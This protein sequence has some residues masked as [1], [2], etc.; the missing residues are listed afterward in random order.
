MFFEDVWVSIM[1]AFFFVCMCVCL[2]DFVC[3]LIRYF[4]TSGRL[5]KSDM[6]GPFLD[7]GLLIAISKETVS[8]V[9]KYNIIYNT[10]C[11]RTSIS[12]LVNQASNYEP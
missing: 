9:L 10:V 11:M 4:V 2:F 1:C 3:L 8:D 5:E 12:M 7:T 6:S